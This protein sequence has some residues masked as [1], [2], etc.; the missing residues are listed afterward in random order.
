MQSLQCLQHEEEPASAGVDLVG[1]GVRFYVTR[2][3][4]LEWNQELDGL[5][6]WLVSLETHRNGYGNMEYGNMN[7][8]SKSDQK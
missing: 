6:Q 3:Q 4:G 2:G 7:I 1:H 8:S 5:F